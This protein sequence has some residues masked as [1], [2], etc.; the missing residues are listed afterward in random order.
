[1]KSPSVQ[2]NNATVNAIPI[3]LAIVTVAGLLAYSK[4]HKPMKLSELSKGLA[5]AFVLTLVVS[6]L[7]MVESAVAQTPT[8]VATLTQSEP[9]VSFAL[10]HTNSSVIQPPADEL[11]HI[12][13]ICEIVFPENQTVLQASNF[14]LTVDVASY[15]WTIDSVYYQADWQDGI[16]QLFG[17]QTNYVNSL[18][19]SI[20]ATFQQIPFG[21]HTLTVYANTHDNSHSNATVTFSTERFTEKPQPSSSF[22]V[23]AVVA[24][25][26]VVFGISVGFM[27]YR[28]HRKTANP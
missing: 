4:K 19:A 28:R 6:S 9:T 13:P 10:W 21:N 22:S 25:I 16:H 23:V 18:N 14:T 12:P 1:M 5:L 26:L 24:V 3:A 15:F 7:M 8:P 2:P 17:I 20:V 11:E 27:L